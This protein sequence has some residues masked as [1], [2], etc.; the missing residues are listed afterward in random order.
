MART[1]RGYAK[2]YLR[3]PIDA[4]ELSH[5]VRD[6]PMV[7]WQRVHPKTDNKVHYSME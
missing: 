4:I 3:E 6:L 7:K 2:A 5:L 1:D